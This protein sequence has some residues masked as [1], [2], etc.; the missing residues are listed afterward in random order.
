ML[1]G[2]GGAERG[3]MGVLVMMMKAT[4]HATRDGVHEEVGLEVFLVL[5]TWGHF[6]FG[7]VVMKP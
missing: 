2:Q 6:H 3:G 1:R 5:V 4:T 7:G